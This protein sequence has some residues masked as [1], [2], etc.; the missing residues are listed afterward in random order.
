LVGLGVCA[1]L[2]APRFAARSCARD[3]PP[4]RPRSHCLRAALALSQVP[5]GASE[6]GPDDTRGHLPVRAR[7]ASAQSRICP[8]VNSGLHLPPITILLPC[9]RRLIELAASPRSPQEDKMADQ[10][11]V[12]LLE[13]LSRSPQDA[14]WR[15]L[16]GVYAP[17]LR[18]WL[19]RYVLQPSDC[20]DLV[21]DV[22]A[23][24][25]R[26]LPSFRHSGRQG[27]F[28]RW[29]RT[30][31]VHR[32]RHF[33]RQQRTRPSSPGDADFQLL[34]EQLGRE[35]SALTLQWDREHDEHVVA[36]LL[37]QIRPDFEG[38][39]WQAFQ[40]Y[41]LDDQPAAAVAEELGLTVNAV[42][43]AKSRVLSRLRAE[44]RGLLE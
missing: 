25:V 27:A 39:T 17:L 38:P 3:E 16:V 11:P 21:Q 12:S 31:L 18:G 42:C 34:V 36:R 24:L 9:I 37:E 20:D 30:I 32:V 29:L 28:R 26:D 19:E 7:S 22:L 10:T 4:G 23:V 44:A 15:R 43:I 41:A 33:W 6:I 1:L 13:R 2:C 8:A 5:P 40:R 35:D 14:D